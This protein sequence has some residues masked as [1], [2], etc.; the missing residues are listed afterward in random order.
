MLGVRLSDNPAAEARAEREC[1]FGAPLVERLALDH[2][3]ELHRRDTKLVDGILQLFELLID[4]IHNIL[5]TLRRVCQI[6]VVAVA[7]QVILVS[8]D[9]RF[10]VARHSQ[11]TVLFEP[12]QGLLVFTVH[13]P[14]NSVVEVDLKL[15]PAGFDVKSVD[16]L[17]E[18]LR[19]LVAL[20]QVSR[21]QTDQVHLKRHS[22]PFF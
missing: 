3:P 16:F 22:F 18:R 9:A 13:F 14:F 17:A 7:R 8:K 6:L 21:C 12:Q 20:L 1:H 4:Q 15:R 19:V 2:V 10:N 5:L 11:D